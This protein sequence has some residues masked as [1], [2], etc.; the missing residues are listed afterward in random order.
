MTDPP[1]PGLCQD[2]RFWSQEGADGD[3]PLSAL[4]LSTRP[5]NCLWK[6]DTIGQL[7]RMTEDEVRCVK[8]LGHWSLVEIKNALA[9]L[10]LSL[11]MKGFPYGKC[12]YA[13]PAVTISQWPETSTDD[14]CGQFQARTP[15][16]EAP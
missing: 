11:G 10:N 7:V 8:N 5:R 14:W 1:P 15:A 13:P 4:G 9:R 2:C 16:P 6:I 12:R 3:R